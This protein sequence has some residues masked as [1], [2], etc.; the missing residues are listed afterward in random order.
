MQGQGAEVVT[1]AT[2]TGGLVM[3]IAVPAKTIPTPQAL[4]TGQSNTVKQPPPPL[5]Q[6]E[7]P[8]GS[9]QPVTPVPVSKEVPQSPPFKAVNPK[10]VQPP[11]PV[12]I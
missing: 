11:P 7:A 4:V 1:T 12:Y 2:I 6:P 8:Q 10:S 5:T 3:P 9:A